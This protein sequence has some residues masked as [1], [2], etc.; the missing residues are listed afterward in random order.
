MLEN[1]FPKGISRKDNH[2][3]W[4]YEL[5]DERVLYH[6][7]VLGDKDYRNLRL[8]EIFENLNQFGGGVEFTR[9]SSEGISN[10]G[11]RYVFTSVESRTSPNYINWQKIE[12][13]NK[14]RIKDKYLREKL[15]GSSSIEEYVSRIYNK[16]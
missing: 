5:S 6:F 4:N 13:D 1:Y 10:E 11:R 7:V 12:P 3:R 15:G 14:R 8:K 9:S 16:S 2:I